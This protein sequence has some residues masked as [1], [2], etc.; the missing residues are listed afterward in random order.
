MMLIYTVIP[1]TVCIHDISARATKLLT[2]SF[3]DF[4]H[5][6]MT[7]QTRE[8]KECPPHPPPSCSATQTPVN[9][10]ES[11]TFVAAGAVSTDNTCTDTNP[12]LK[13][14]MSRHTCG[15]K[16]PVRSV[17]QAADKKQREDLL[18]RLCTCLC[19]NKRGQDLDEG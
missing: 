19:A 13:H 8:E 3:S 15:M 14:L 9:A 18:F 4:L 17:N 2:K 6:D 5:S 1:C 11:Q 16:R 10:A 7:Y 12:G